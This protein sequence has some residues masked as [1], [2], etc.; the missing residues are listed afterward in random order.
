[1]ARQYDDSQD[2]QYL[3][4]IAADPLAAAAE[5]FFCIHGYA[6]DGS[7]P[8]TRLRPCGIGATAGPPA[9]RRHPGQCP[10]YSSTVKIVDDGTSGEDPVWLSPATGYPNAGA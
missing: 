3:Q 6:S 8:P 7:T 10:C 9:R 4:N 5:A 1:M 2:L